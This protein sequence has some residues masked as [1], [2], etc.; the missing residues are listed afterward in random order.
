MLCSATAAIPL[1]ARAHAAHPMPS[2]ASKP[3]LGLVILTFMAAALRL[4]AQVPPPE[5]DAMV[6]MDVGPLPAP[7]VRGCATAPFTFTRVRPGWGYD[8]GRAV[9]FGGVLVC[10][11]AGAATLSFKHELVRWDATEC[12]PQLLSVRR[13][14]SLKAPLRRRRNN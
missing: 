2:T 14:L 11:A 13:E 1:P 4:T 12:S 8:D 10:E 5:V 6:L 3:L 9:R 7:A